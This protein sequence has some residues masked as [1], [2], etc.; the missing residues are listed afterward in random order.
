MNIPDQRISDLFSLREE[1]ESGQRD[2]Y[3]R[4]LHRFSAQKDISK[5]VVSDYFREHNLQPVIEWPHGKRYAI[6]LSHDIDLIDWRWYTL[7]ELGLRSL[8]KRKWNETLKYWQLMYQPQLR[9]LRNFQTIM[10]L[11]KKYGAQSTFFFMATTDHDQRYDIWTLEEELKNIQAQGFEVALHGGMESYQDASILIQEKERLEQVLGAKVIGIRQHYLRFDLE[12]T[13]Q[14]QEAAGLLYDATLG[15]AD[16]IGFRNGMCFPFIPE[17]RR[18]VEIPLVV[19]DST[20]WS[21][22]AYD[23]DTAWLQ[24]KQLIDTV[25]ERGG[26][27]SILWHNDQFVE[28]LHPRSAELYE[29]ILAY[30]QE[31]GAWMTSA[32]EIYQQTRSQIR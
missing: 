25:Q 11:E 27:I 6:C 3:N 23:F 28:A 10:D 16:Q 32:A 20:L 29:K 9:N 7:A 26:L 5:P 30:G 17:G 2:Q 15:Y 4:Y 13:W 31:S 1:Q 12:K 14:A 24:T 22:L 8:G 19:M 21:Y 18:M